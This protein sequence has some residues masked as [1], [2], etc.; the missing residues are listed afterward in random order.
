VDSLPPP[1]PASYS[2]APGDIYPRGAR[3]EELCA[4]AS[5][6]DWLYLAG[7][8]ALDVAAFYA[9]STDNIKN[10]DSEPVRFAGPA[11]IGLTWG[12]TVGG[13]F[14]ALPKCEPHWVGASPRAGGVRASWPIALSLALFAGAT[15]PIVN[16]I[17]VGTC[18]DNCQGGLPAKWDTLER[19]MHLVTA[20]VAGLGGALLPYLLPPRTWAAAKE[21]ERMRVG[22]DAR[23][24]VVLAISGTF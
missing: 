22:A 21:L 4:Q 13:G 14:L 10:A 1:P 20:G 5:H 3:E 11:M 18:S 15:A 19:E 9:G 2:Y 8:A 17:A 6:A 24:N 23:G 12:A 16:A 7:L